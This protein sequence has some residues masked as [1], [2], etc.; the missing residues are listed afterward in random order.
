[1]GPLESGVIDH[2]FKL[3]TKVVDFKAKF[4]VKLC[5]VFEESE[6]YLKKCIKNVSKMQRLS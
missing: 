1:M 4:R 5:R 2:I 3:L 6:F